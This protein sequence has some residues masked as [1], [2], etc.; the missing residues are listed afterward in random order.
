M[1]SPQLVSV[2][3]SW[4]DNS[5]YAAGFC[6]QAIWLDKPPVLSSLYRTFLVGEVISPFVIVIIVC[7]H[8]LFHV[9][10]IAHFDYSCCC[11]LLFFSV[12]I[13]SWFYLIWELTYRLKFSYFAHTHLYLCLNMDF[14]L[15]KGLVIISWQ[16]QM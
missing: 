5:N 12:K 14:I 13:D 15:Y 7:V 1:N 4:T 6:C 10:F 11:H 2:T 16:G 8:C 3:S 9:L